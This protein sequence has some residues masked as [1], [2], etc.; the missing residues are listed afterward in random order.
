[1]RGVEI[2]IFVLR[3]I[4]VSEVTVNFRR[5]LSLLLMKF[6]GRGSFKCIHTFTVSSACYIIFLEGCGEKQ[7]PCIIVLW[8]V[9]GVFGVISVSYHCHCHLVICKKI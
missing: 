7:L 3:K 9:V 6:F 2:T 1:M 8:M 4:A 5:V